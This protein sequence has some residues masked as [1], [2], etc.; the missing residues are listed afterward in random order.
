MGCGCHGTLAFELQIV[1]Q[2]RKQ[3][4]SVNNNDK[5]VKSAMLIMLHLLTS[6]VEIKIFQLCKS[7]FDLFI[8]KLHLY[9]INASVTIYGSGFKCEIFV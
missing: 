6:G 7:N 9:L 5:P 4:Y 2:C 8:S 1:L 3:A